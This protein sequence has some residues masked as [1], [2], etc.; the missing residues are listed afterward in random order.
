M[1][2]LLEWQTHYEA[3]TIRYQYKVLQFLSINKQLSE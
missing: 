1:D 2:L 3:E